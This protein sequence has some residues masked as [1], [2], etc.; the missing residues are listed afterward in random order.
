MGEKGFKI[1]KN[2][3][4]WTLIPTLRLGLHEGGGGFIVLDWLRGGLCYHW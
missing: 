3:Y 1:N 2:Y 4:A